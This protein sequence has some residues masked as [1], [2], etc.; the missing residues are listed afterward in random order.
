MADLCKTFYTNL[1]R[2][3]T[4]MENKRTYF[5]ER[6]V[7]N[8]YVHSYFPNIYYDTNHQNFTLSGAQV[9]SPAVSKPNTYMWPQ[10]E[11]CSSRVSRK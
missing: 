2:K 11:S 4:V 7:V 6:H 5:T 8:F 3:F 10:Q 1:T 9:R